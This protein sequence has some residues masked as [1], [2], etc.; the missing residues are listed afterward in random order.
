LRIGIGGE[1][2]TAGRTVVRL[3]LKSDISPITFM[4]FRLL[5]M[6]ERSTQ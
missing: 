5:D 6:G 3:L 2:L 4:G 1:L